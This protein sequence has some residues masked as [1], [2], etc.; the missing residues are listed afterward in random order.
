MGKIV[1]E[2]QAVLMGALMAYPQAD[3]LLTSHGETP[4]M[5][6]WHDPQRSVRRSVGC[7]SSGLPPKHSGGD[8][9]HFVAPLVRRIHWECAPWM[10]VAR[11]PV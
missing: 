4:W 9:G 1:G 7:R 6:L 3:G 11:G 8:G 10:L 5:M 2:K